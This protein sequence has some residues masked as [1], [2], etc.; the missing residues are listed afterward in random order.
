MR[1]T[2]ALVIGALQCGLIQTAIAGTLPNPPVSPAPVVKYG[3]DANG[4]PTTTTVAPGVLDYTSTNHYDNLDRVDTNTDARNKQSSYGYDG[5]DRN[6]Q[7]TDPRS[8]VTQTPRNGL[9][10]VKQLLSP[11]TGTSGYTYDAAGNL[12]TKTDSRGVTAAY[13]WDALNRPLSVTY[14]GTGFTTETYGWVYDQVVSPYITNGVGRLT[15][16]DYPAGN[17]RYGYDALG[18]VVYHQ[19]QVF[20]A[21]NINARVWKLITYGYDGAGHLTSITYPSG[22]QIN[23]T[24]TNGALSGISL[25]LSSTS[26]T[27]YPLLNNIHWTPDGQADS[28]SWQLTG[29]ATL[30]YSRSYDTY[31]RLVRYPLG[32]TTRDITYDDGDRI[33]AY[34]HYDANANPQPS[35]DQ[36]FGYDEL[37]RLTS[38]A[39][40]STTWGIQ[41]DDNGNRK[42]FTTNGATQNYTIDAASN[43][44]NTVDTP[45]RS[46]GYDSAGNTQSDSTSYTAQYNARGQL[47]S[48]TKAGKTTSYAYNT[49]GQ[50][51][52][53]TDGTTAGTT[54][55]A[56]D[57]NTGNLLGEYDTNGNPIVEYVWMGD[58]P[59]AEFTPTP[60]IYYVYTDHLNTP[61]AVI[62][63]SNNLRWRWISE[64][65]GNTV[66]E[67]NPSNLGAFAFNLRFPG[68]YA[69]QE[70]GLFYN[71]NRYYDPSLGRYQQSDPIGLA[72]GSWSTYQYVNSSPVDTFDP[73]G[74]DPVGRAV[75][76]QIGGWGVGALGLELGPLD[77]VAVAGGRWVGGLAGDLIGDW[78]VAEATGNPAKDRAIPSVAR[79]L[80]YERA[81]NFCDSEPPPGQNDCSTLSK[82][83]DHANQCI[84]FYEQW[85][86]K[87]L[88]GRHAKKIQTWKNRLKNLKDEHNQKCAQTCP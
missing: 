28:W 4:N 8:L 23:Y 72:G 33:K 7:V 25:Q 57:Y 85:D 50:R 43:K 54:V 65:F 39:T 14:T 12:K 44:I 51:I 61:R 58:T 79:Q 73:N 80:E 11:D 78:I 5:L 86:S 6:I 83:I 38:I 17:V 27:T 63:K 68:Q 9:G 76:A 62:D 82:E 31:G 22:R 42:V 30:P 26:T 41:Y 52:R 71:W 75:G 66:P 69:D 24:Y 20:A 45:A 40:S 88:P 16:H 48:I 15:G 47:L 84:A 70:S 10:D 1:A 77:A 60:T 21:T 56:Y 55:Y 59:V 87:W 32:S 46:F 18:R 53:K 49:L 67:T 64:P 13:R 2:A 35:W 29:T 81:K 37:G 36:S 3:Y 19:W 34:T 74:L